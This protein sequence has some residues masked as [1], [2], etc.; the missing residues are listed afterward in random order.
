MELVVAAETETVQL[1]SDG[2][3]PP[4]ESRTTEGMAK[5][6]RREPQAVADRIKLFDRASDKEADHVLVCSRGCVFR[7]VVYSAREGVL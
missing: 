2:P 7:P 3:G 4:T 6:G 5:P 1:A